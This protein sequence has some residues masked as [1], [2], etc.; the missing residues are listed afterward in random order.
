MK[1]CS[2]R[3]ESAR[4]DRSL[5]FPTEP[6][7][8]E[9]SPF[10]LK[11][12]YGSIRTRDMFRDLGGYYCNSYNGHTLLYFSTEGITVVSSGYEKTYPQSKLKEALNDYE[13]I[14]RAYKLQK[15]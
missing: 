11:T 10:T 2:Q 8:R 3:M 7:S 6:L 4:L 12:P 9:V 15:N 13:R 14:I 5:G 1:I